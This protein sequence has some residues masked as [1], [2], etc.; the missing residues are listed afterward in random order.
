MFD[1][2]TALESSSDISDRINEFFS[3]TIDRVNAEKGECKLF[4]LLKN[5]VDWDYETMKEMEC[6]SL[7][8]KPETLVAIHSM[9]CEDGKTCNT[10]FQMLHT[11]LSVIANALSDKESLTEMLM[12]LDFFLKEK[13]NN[14]DLT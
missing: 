5:G 13:M 14:D 6:S 7:N 8:F 9:K 10:V 2:D 3:D 1:K 12:A 4:E 11:K